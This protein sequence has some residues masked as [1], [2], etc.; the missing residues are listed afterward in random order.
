MFDLGPPGKVPPFPIVFGVILRLRS[1]MATLT[2]TCSSS[3]EYGGKIQSNLKWL[4]DVRFNLCAVYPSPHCETQ[5]SIDIT[6]LCT[7]VV[8]GQSWHFSKN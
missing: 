4:T 3:L 6:V 7:T 8:S 2:G 1:L 5:A